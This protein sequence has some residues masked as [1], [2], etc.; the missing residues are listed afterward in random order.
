MLPLGEYDMVSMHSLGLYK[1]EL[2]VFK[3]FDCLFELWFS[4]PVNRYGHARMLP[5]FDGTST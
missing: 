3:D 5:T 1:Y 4:I 2:E